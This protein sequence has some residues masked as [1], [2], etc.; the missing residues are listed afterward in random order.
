MIPRGQLKPGGQ[1]TG[2]F[3]PDKIRRWSARPVNVGA[4]KEGREPVRHV[5]LCGGIRRENVEA[6]CH[7]VVLNQILHSVTELVGNEGRLSRK[8]AFQCHANRRP[9]Q[10]QRELASVELH[11][12]M[13]RD[14]RMIGIVPC[15]ATRAGDAFR[16]HDKIKLMKQTPRLRRG[17]NTDG[18][19]P[20]NF[21]SEVRLQRRPA[22]LCHARE[23]VVAGLDPTGTKS[24]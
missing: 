23:R 21:Y 2:Q 13:N 15:G 14:G 6:K 8:P 20:R 3:P 16:Q 12:C 19:L 17:R 9:S 24:K 18:R 22:C 1:R 7:A 4:S 5:P 11:F 10:G